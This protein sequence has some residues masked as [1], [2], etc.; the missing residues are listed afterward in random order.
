MLPSKIVDGRLTPPLEKEGTI[1]RVDPVE[2]N[3]LCTGAE[4]THIAHYK[5]GGERLYSTRARSR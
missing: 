5:K 3:K 4:D 2:G 1:Y